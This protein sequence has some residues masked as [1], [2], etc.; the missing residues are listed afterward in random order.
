MST[1]PILSA[2][3][4]SRRALTRRSVLLGST[5]LAGA[6]LLA[7]CAPS[8][9]SSSVSSTTAA[10]PAAVSTDIASVGDVTL[11]VWDQEVRG[12]QNEQMEQLNKAFMAKYPS[13]T[14]KRVSQSF[15]DLQTT[16]RLALTGADAPDVVEANNGRNTMG[17]FVAAGQLV[18]LDPW[19]SV[20]GW[21][22]SYSE[23]ILSYSR[24]STDG[25]T[26][27]EGSLWGLPQVG[28]AVGVYY[29]PSRLKKL[30]LEVPT[31]WEDLADQLGTIKDAGETPLMLGNVEKW[32]ALHVFGP[33]QGAHVP[34]DQ[35]RK[36]GFGNAGASWSTDENLAAATQLQ[37]WA[38][39]GYFNDGFNG[40]DYDTV[41]QDFS[42]GTG[43][44]LIAGSWLAPDLKSVL[45]DD[46]AFMLP[47][48]STSMDKVA[49]TGG[50]GLPFAITSAAKK[51]D[52]AAA[53][54]DFI[55][56]ADAMKVLAD[57]GNVPVNDTASFAAAAGGVTGDVMSAFEE[58]TTQGEVLP[59]LDYA[60]PTFDQ[61][62]GDALQSLLDSKSTP[63][64]FLDTLEAA[65]TE[66]TGA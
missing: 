61:V 58:V 50:T 38:S 39:K 34:A 2:S 31:T 49:T 53:Y 65:Y 16:L 28:E 14:I 29:S 32:P 9:G 19:I 33:V 7:A 47:P 55:T 37:E 52:V 42:K 60:T 66:F 22:K 5:A 15:D 51:P 12:G 6:G 13:V 27:G 26:F 44:Y 46:V 10:T 11:T 23:S 1:R 24:Y 36:L 4:G 59:Y 25:K 63:Q 48:K 35:I 3:T 54:I 57:T 18:A 45:G 8:G 56:N 20:Y 64:E 41:W 62:L 17:Q 30:G 43:I 40:V 21:D